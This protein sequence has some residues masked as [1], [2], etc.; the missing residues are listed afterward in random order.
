MGRAK[1]WKRSVVH[2]NPRVCPFDA[3]VHTRGLPGGVYAYQ[4]LPPSGDPNSGARWDGFCRRGASWGCIGDT[5]P[6][7]FGTYIHEHTRRVGRR[8][9]SSACSRV[10][11]NLGPVGD[12]IVVMD[13]RGLS[14]Q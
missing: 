13:R 11:K 12:L 8:A 7:S 3:N 14:A 9:S 4:P 6:E 1:Q 10:D 5:N 2:G